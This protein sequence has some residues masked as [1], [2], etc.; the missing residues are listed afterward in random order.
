MDNTDALFADVIAMVN[1]NANVINDTLHMTADSVG[2]TLSNSLQTIWGTSF[3]SLQGVVTT[4]G[5]GF[6]SQLTTTN[7]AINN[8]ASLVANMQAYSN[9]WANSWIGGVNN[10]YTPDISSWTPSGGLDTG[11]NNY[12]WDTEYYDDGPTYTTPPPQN[13]TTQKQITVGGR[14]NAAG[15]TIY[16]RS[17]RSDGGTTQYY[18]SDPIYTVLSQQQNKYGETMLLVRHHSKSSGNTGWFR[19]SDVRAYKHGGLVDQTGLVWLDGTKQKPETVLDA[20]DTKR[21]Q[22]LVESMDKFASK[23]FKMTGNNSITQL[24]GKMLDGG[25]ASVQKSGGPITQE[26]AITIPIDHV[27]DYDDFI[28]RLREDKNGKKII[29]ALALD[30]ILGKNSLGARKYKA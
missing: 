10:S 2:Y 7:Q 9:S 5:E 23:G 15:A 20:D 16:R 21:F 1:Q 22:S 12:D 30:D 29:Q 19:M 14:I 28:N 18:G 17:D 6:L 13:V 8:I 25:A 26:I 3:N 4:Y 27:D 11:G 24:V